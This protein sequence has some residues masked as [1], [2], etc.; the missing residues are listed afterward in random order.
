MQ[1]DRLNSVNL[2]S[3]IPKERRHV[4]FRYNHVQFMYLIPNSIKEPTGSPEHQPG[5]RDGPQGAKAGN[6]LTIVSIYMEKSLHKLKKK[7][8]SLDQSGEEVIRCL[9]KTFSSRG[10]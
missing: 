4:V 6:Q 5:P 7:L 3:F 10:N 9:L 8:K 2:L 1:S